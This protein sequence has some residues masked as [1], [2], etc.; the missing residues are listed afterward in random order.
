MSERRVLVCSDCEREYPLD[1]ELRKVEGDDRLFCNNEDCPTM[2]SDD[3]DT[4]W[5]V[6]VR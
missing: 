5:E 1:A 6:Q 3:V 4:E 2:E